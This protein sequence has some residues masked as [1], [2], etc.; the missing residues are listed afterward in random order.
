MVNWFIYDHRIYI[1]RYAVHNIFARYAVGSPSAQSCGLLVENAV[2][3]FRLDTHKIA[4]DNIKTFRRVRCF[5]LNGFCWTLDDGSFQITRTSKMFISF[6]FLYFSFGFH[7]K[8]FCQSNYFRL[9][10]FFIFRYFAYFLYL[11]VVHVAIVCARSRYILNKI[12]WI[13]T[14]NF[15]Q[16][17]NFYEFYAQIAYFLTKCQ[18]S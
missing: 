11:T 3:D 10:E 12:L 8:L 14:H 1:G 4:C 2:I 16:S 6:F 18:F 5:L 17:E 9:Y 7:K 15:C 13:N